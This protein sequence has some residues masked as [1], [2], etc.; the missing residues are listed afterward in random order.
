MVLAKVA[1]R[2]HLKQLEQYE[3]PAR[4][5]AARRGTRTAPSPLR[6][7][8]SAEDL[9]RAAAV[10]VAARTNLPAVDV[11]PKP[12]VPVKLVKVLCNVAPSSQ[13]KTINR[14]TPTRFVPHCTR[15]R[16]GPFPL[17]NVV[18][19]PPEAAPVAP[20][21][22]SRPMFT[23]AKENGLLFRFPAA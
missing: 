13:L 12:V 5:D 23:R 21:S 18:C 4:F 2:C 10:L 9:K 6:S 22:A 17:H 3:L 16:P 11:N 14:E 1:P 7:V 15:S 19:A 20:T 8:V